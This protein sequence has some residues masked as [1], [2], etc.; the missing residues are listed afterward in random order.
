[1]SA[2]LAAG[3]L[4]AA[5]FPPLGC[6]PAVVIGV[7]LLLTAASGASRKLAFTL[8]C[9]AGAVG[10]TAAVHW[11][12]PTV[13]RFAGVSVVPAT[14][15]FA[16]F[17]V[18][19]ALQLGIFSA[20]IADRGTRGLVFHCAATAATWVVI[21]WGFPHM[22]PWTLGDA[23]A[24]S[25]I[26]RQGADIA[27]THGLSFL[28]VFCAAAFASAAGGRDRC[29]AIGIGIT[30]AGAVAGYGALCLAME[31]NEDLELPRMDAVALQGGIGTFADGAPQNERAWATYEK[32]TLDYARVAARGIVGALT[33]WPEMT[34]RSHLRHDGRRRQQLEDLALSARRALLIGA[35]DLHPTG[36]DL[37]SAFLLSPPDAGRDP[38]LQ[39]YDKQILVPF[40]E[41]LPGARIISL[42]WKPP[43]GLTPGEYRGP[44]EIAGG[45]RLGVSICFEV[46]HAGA[47]NRVVQDG[48]AFLVNLADDGWFAG[49]VEPRQHLAGAA[50]RAVETRRW[51]VRASDSGISALIDPTGRVVSEL[52]VG[53]V[54]AVRGMVPLRQELTPYVRYGNWIVLL[55]C[56]LAAARLAN[57]R[58]SGRRVVGSRRCQQSDCP[59]FNSPT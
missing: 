43:G 31:R 46:L 34:L 6:S 4:I 17:A 42:M 9:C 8:G 48:A 15:I 55:S 13:S 14:L 19:H 50:M 10:F 39:S 28:I 54:G 47:S 45:I 36:G 12:I 37:N 11:L 35:R 40:G 22:L 20:A 32:L 30:V 1:V 7:T 3:S 24:G 51:L 25:A 21:E 56:L 18:Y 16:A 26:L 27:G 41:Y 52:A 29:A 33:V 57:Q 2:A 59:Q 23:L 53:S 38:E 49:D 58:L 44:L 5:A